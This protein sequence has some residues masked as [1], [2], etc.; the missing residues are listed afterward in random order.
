MPRRQNSGGS[1]PRKWKP[2]GLSRTP[3]RVKSFDRGDFDF[4]SITPS[5]SE[6]MSMLDPETGALIFPEKE[7]IMP[8]PE[9]LPYAPEQW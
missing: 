2:P 1:R 8:A 4:S 6:E 5:P 7:K 9:E 3:K